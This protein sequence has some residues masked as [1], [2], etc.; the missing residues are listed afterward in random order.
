VRILCCDAEDIV[1]AHRNTGRQGQGLAARDHEWLIRNDESAGRR[2]RRQHWAKPCSK[3]SGGGLFTAANISMDKSGGLKG[4]GDSA[5]DRLPKITFDEVSGGRHAVRMRHGFTF[6]HDDAPIRERGPEMIICT[7]VSK[8]EFKHRSLEAL[9][10]TDCK[11]K[12]VAL[13]FQAP[14]CTI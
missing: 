4:F 11:I 14:N 1:S 9:D 2:Q 10:Q 3:G 12:T 7:P 8:A 6:K 5:W 13:G